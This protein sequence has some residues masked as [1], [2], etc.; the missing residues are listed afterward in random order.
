MEWT[1]IGTHWVHFQLQIS[2]ENKMFTCYNHIVIIIIVGFWA[3]SIYTWTVKSQV[4]IVMS[5]PKTLNSKGFMYIYMIQYVQCIV[6]NTHTRQNCSI[7]VLSVIDNFFFHVFKFFSHYL[8]NLKALCGLFAN[9]LMTRSFFLYLFY[10]Q[11]ISLPDNLYTDCC[12]SDLYLSRMTLHT[13]LVTS[14]FYITLQVMVVHKEK[15]CC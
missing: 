11:A 8:A 13:L 6:L 4:M 14:A 5:R 2:Q 9:V 1:A 3:V 7:R 10:L 12:P 15:V